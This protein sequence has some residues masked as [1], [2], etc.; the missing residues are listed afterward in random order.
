MVPFDLPGLMARGR[1]FI[2]PR[3]VIAA[4]VCAFA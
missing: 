1:F 2:P 4:F 3:Q